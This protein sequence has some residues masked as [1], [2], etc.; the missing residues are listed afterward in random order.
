MAKSKATPKTPLTPDVQSVQSVK[1]NI[2]TSLK[3]HKQFR[4]QSGQMYNYHHQMIIHLQEQL[5][6]IERSEKQ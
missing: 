5:D 6:Q 2:Q 3:H 1:E 4:D